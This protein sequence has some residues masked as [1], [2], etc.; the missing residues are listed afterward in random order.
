MAEQ[1]FEQGRMLWR[2]EDGS[3]LV[4]NKD[5][6]WNGYVDLWHDGLAE[7]SCEGSP[8]GNLQQP[9]RG[10]GLVWC[11]EEAVG[12]ELG[13]ATDEE[14]GMAHT[15]QLFEYGQMISGGTRPVIYTLF[16]NGTFAEYPAK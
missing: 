10:F 8:P 4:F 16:Q 7:Y 15:W 9:K 5:G 3:L 14:Q 1:P 2:E 13:W 6:T 12:G 11:K